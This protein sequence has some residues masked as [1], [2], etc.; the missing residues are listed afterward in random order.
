MLS[1]RCYSLLLNGERGG[2]VFLSVLL[3]SYE[4]GERDHKAMSKE[5]KRI[6][7]CFLSVLLPSY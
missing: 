4:E 7:G 1:F 3:P 6:Y 5:L 2:Y